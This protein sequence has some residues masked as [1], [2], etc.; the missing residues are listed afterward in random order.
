[1]G[2]HDVKLNHSHRHPQYIYI[3]IYI[4]IL[5]WHHLVRSPTWKI[6]VFTADKTVN[7]VWIGVRISRAVLAGFSYHSNLIYTFYSFSQNYTD[8]PVGSV[9]IYIYI[10]ICSNEGKEIY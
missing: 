6:M 10:Y 2:C 3:Y 1:M 9:L 4:Y 5:I 7:K 8:D